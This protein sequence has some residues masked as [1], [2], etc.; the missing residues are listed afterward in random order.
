[1]VWFSAF[2]STASLQRPVLQQ[3]KCS[4]DKIRFL[5]LVSTGRK[6][7][8]TLRREPNKSSRRS[9]SYIAVFEI[10]HS[11][12]SRLDT[13]KNVKIPSTIKHSLP[14]LIEAV[15]SEA[16][17]STQ[18]VHDTLSLA[19]QTTIRPKHSTRLSL[20]AET[21]STV[22]LQNLYHGKPGNQQDC[23]RPVLA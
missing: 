14:N 8:Y 17:P 20:L 10:D 18:F 13:K 6:I 5:Y 12:N 22:S 19:L 15:L 7:I 21:R 11:L 4:G 3:S 23:I 16:H 1:M 2:P 9:A